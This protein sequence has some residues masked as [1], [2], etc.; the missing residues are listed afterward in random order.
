MLKRRR[1]TASA[2][3]IDREWAMA[4]A[5]IGQA[6]NSISREYDSSKILAEQKNLMRIM[7]KI[8]QK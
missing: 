8:E 4:T 7:A 5:Y 6:I 1:M 2:R 3:P